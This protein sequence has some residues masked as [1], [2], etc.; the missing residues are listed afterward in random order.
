MFPKIKYIIVSVCTAFQIKV[1]R[2]ISVRKVRRILPWCIII[3]ALLLLLIFKDIEINKTS[4]LHVKRSVSRSLNTK[5]YNSDYSQSQLIINKWIHVKED[6]YVYSA[7]WEYRKT[8]SFVR[9]IA[10]GPKKPINLST[11]S[12][13]L[14]Y[15][16][17]SV[18]RSDINY[19]FIPEDH[20][21][22]HISLFFYCKASDIPERVALT[23]TKQNATHWIKVA[24]TEPVKGNEIWQSNIAVCVRPFFGEFPNNNLQLAEFI[25]YY[26]IMGVQHFTFYDYKAKNSI[27]LLLN[28]SIDGG[29]P[30]SL[31]P[32]NLPTDVRDAWDYGHLANIADCMYRYA[33]THKYVVI[34]DI[35]ELIL[36]QQ[37]ISLMDIIKTYN[38]SW[39]TLLFRNTFFSLDLP[40]DP[41]VKNATIPLTILKKTLHFTP[42]EPYLRT[43][44]IVLPSKVEIPGIHFTWKS[45][46]N[47]KTITAEPTF[48]KL[49]HYRH[50]G[51]K[52]KPVIRDQTAWRYSDRILKSDPIKIWKN[53]TIS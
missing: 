35:D 48:A 45:I 33:K 39:S 6:Y 44:G 40:D 11:F 46:D 14:K 15:N 36:P 9:I 37:N 5:T 50:R 1:R 52:E 26:Q 29:I 49:H 20:Y 23:S 47:S 16:N 18:K 51:N 22:K 28:A 13:L 32:W 8:P 53:L 3:A 31:F 12:C 2:I 27:K 19:E 34:V 42:M 4:N 41:E 24:L 10:I 38:S 30:I 43:K 7:Y 21:Q 25:A 17:G